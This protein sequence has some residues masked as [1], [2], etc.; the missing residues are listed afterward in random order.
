MVKR[1]GSVH[2]IWY[3]EPT[4]WASEQDSR[5]NKECKFLNK[6]FKKYNVKKVLDVG[7]GA[8]SHCIELKKLGYAPVGVDLNKKL[9]QYAK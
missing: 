4:L 9:I 3:D 5:V 6:L 7:C 1:D 8:G 2:R